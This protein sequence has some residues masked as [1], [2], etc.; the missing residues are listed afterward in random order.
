MLKYHPRRQQRTIDITCQWRDRE[1]IST[2]DWQMSSPCTIYWGEMT[3]FAAFKW[4]WVWISL[5]THRERDTYIILYIHTIVTTGF[6]IF[7]LTRLKIAI[8]I[9]E[10]KRGWFSDYTLRSPSSPSPPLVLLQL[11][12]NRTTLSRLSRHE[13]RQ[14]KI[15]FFHFFLIPF[16]TTV[17]N[18]VSKWR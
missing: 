8:N 10:Q 3:F 1:D 15:S 18:V 14:R 2:W 7:E 5:T 13:M 6:I 11:W 4:T 12:N 16:F 17:I 9:R